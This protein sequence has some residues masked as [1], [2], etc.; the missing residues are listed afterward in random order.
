MSSL[1]KDIHPD[2]A[3][4]YN[5]NDRVVCYDIDDERNV[6][7]HNGLV[8]GIIDEMFPIT[9]PYCG[10]PNYKVYCSTLLTDEKNGDFDTRAVIHAANSDTGEIIQINRYFKESGNRWVEISKE[11][12]FE[13]YIM[14]KRRRGFPVYKETRML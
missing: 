7:Y 1:F 9:M 4:T 11:E 3:V 12:Y 10:G 6:P 5:D 13:R 2:G 14:D 8:S